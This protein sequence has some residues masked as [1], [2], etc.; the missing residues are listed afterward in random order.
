M[1]QKAACTSRHAKPSQD[2]SSTNNNDVDLEDDIPASML[3]YI[4]QALRL[5]AFQYI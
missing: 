3:G 2:V 4:L 5:E 1:R